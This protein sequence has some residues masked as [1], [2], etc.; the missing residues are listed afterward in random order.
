M[1]LSRCVHVSTALVKCVGT[2]QGTFLPGSLGRTNS[3]SLYLYLGFWI[4]AQKKG[5]LILT[6]QAACCSLLEAGLFALFQFLLGVHVG[7]FAPK[8]CSFPK[9]LRSARMAVAYACTV[10]ILRGSPV[11]GLIRVARWFKKDRIVSSFIGRSERK[12]LKSAI[13]DS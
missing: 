13:I 10:V 11:R 3:L 5:R 12:A 9:A 2:C 4:N 8:R 6:D 7:N 1:H